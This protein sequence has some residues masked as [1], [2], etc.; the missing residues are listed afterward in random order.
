[1]VAALLVVGAAV[2]RAQVEQLELRRLGRY[3]KRQAY[4]SSR[5]GIGARAR[6]S[7]EV[8]FNRS[9]LEIALG[10]GPDAQMLAV[11]AIER[12]ETIRDGIGLAATNEMIRN[13]ADAIGAMVGGAVY[14]VA[15]DVVAWVQP[16]DEASVQSVLDQIQL[17]F[18]SPVPTQSGPVDVSFTFGFERDEGGAAAVL[19]IERALSAIGTARAL[20]KSHGLDHSR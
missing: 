18:R 7:G 6:H 3:A 19:R 11:A 9:V 15:P 16:D 12:F 5:G 1:M 10:S 2:G 13:S 17:A 14:R 20:G 8:R 4:E